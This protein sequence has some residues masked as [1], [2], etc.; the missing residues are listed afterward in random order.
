MESPNPE[1]LN[2]IVEEI[3]EGLGYQLFINDEEPEN[4]PDRVKFRQLVQL[5][6]MELSAE[7]FVATGNPDEDQQ[8]A[9]YI[10]RATPAFTSK[11]RPQVAK[12]EYVTAE[13]A[14]KTKS[15][16]Q[17]QSQPK[18]EP[19]KP[20]GGTQI[21][22]VNHQEEKTS[23][24]TSLLRSLSFSSVSVFGTAMAIIFLAGFLAAHYSGNRGSAFFNP[25]NQT[26]YNRI[27]AGPKDPKQQ[28]AAKAF[29]MMAKSELEKKNHQAAREGFRM[30]L[31]LEPDNPQYQEAFKQ[32]ETLTKGSKKKTG[33]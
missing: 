28:R 20:A 1:K 25:G 30:A 18:A 13:I 2:Q 31:S 21:R 3:V 19:A 9:P 33:P 6:E 8:P 11:N 12:V 27:A 15:E 16:S 10:S 7:L 29:F 24:G 32:I 26:S 23:A 5:I 4:D 14:A 17:S 22:L